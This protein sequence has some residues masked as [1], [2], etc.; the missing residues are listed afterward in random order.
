MGQL[1]IQ[2][3]QKKIG[4]AFLLYCSLFMEIKS[5]LSTFLSSSLQELSNDVHVV[6]VLTN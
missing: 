5:K 4:Q 1:Y 3:G 2:S 6:M